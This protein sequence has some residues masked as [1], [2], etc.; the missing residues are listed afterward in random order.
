MCIGYKK[1]GSPGPPLLGNENFEEVSC[2][3]HCVRKPARRAR[4]KCLCANV[5]RLGGLPPRPK[6]LIKR[7]GRKD[8]KKTPFGDFRSPQVAPGKTT[9][10]AGHQPK[11][12]AHRSK[13]GGRK[14]MKKTF[15]VVPGKKIRSCLFGAGCRGSS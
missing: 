8:M 1:V 9:Q 11:R 13:N 14:C 15:Q 4:L 2:S 6:V 12:K 3:C 5:V 10:V 7:G